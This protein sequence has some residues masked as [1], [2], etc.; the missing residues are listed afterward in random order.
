[1]KTVSNSDD[2]IDVRD[3]IERIEELREQLSDAEC[4]DKLD[5]NEERD[6]LKTLEELME[7][8]EGTGGDEQWEG[9]WYPLTLIRDS[10]FQAYAEEFAEDCG[11]INKD[12][13]WPNNCID[14]EKAT[15]DLQY[16]YTPIDYED[17]TYW[18]R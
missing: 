6:E 5:N 11:L 18:V 8:L 15:R 3:I 12:A 17:V 13:K 4:R 16:D 10:Y 2:L 9:D 7:S 14:W 1:M